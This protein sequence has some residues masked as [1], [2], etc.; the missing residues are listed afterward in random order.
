[1][2]VALAVVPVLGGCGDQV[3]DTNESANQ[4][5]V[6][7]NESANQPAVNQNESGNPAGNEVETPS[8][9]KATWVVYTLP[10]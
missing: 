3:P 5:A 8:T 9:A 7:Q 2:A 4:P 6:D 10:G 1:M